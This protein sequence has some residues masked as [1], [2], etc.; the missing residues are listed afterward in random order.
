MTIPFWKMQSIGNDFPV[1]HMT[2]VINQDVSALAIRICDRHFGVGGDGLLIVGMEG[3]DVRLRM[4][5]PDG[6]EDFCGNGLRCAAQHSVDM[7]WVADAFQ[8]LHLD[9]TV[10]TTV[11]DGRVTN[12]LGPASYEPG[13]VPHLFI[14]EMFDCTIWS[15]LVGGYPLSLFG[16]A[17]TT[18]STHVVIPTAAIPDDETFRTVA[19]LIEHHEKFPDRTSVIW[20]Q[21]TSPMKIKIRVWERGVGETMGCGT[22]SSAAAADYLRRKNAI[23]PVPAGYKVEVQNPGGTVTVSTSSWFGNLRLEGTATTTFTGT[24]SV[25]EVAITQPANEA[26][27]SPNP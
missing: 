5:N 7:G 4:F 1:V 17:L 26:A 25:P 15:G 22:G 18:G 6:T 11:S 10:P 14:R 3:A 12:L 21:E 9:R 19:P 24:F 27:P 16:S 23:A 2:D 20:V 8:M 13:R